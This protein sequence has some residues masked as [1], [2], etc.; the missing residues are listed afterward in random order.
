MVSASN[1]V[2][3]SMIFEQVTPSY[4]LNVA[5]SQAFAVEPDFSL[6]WCGIQGTLELLQILHL[7]QIRCQ[8]LPNATVPL[9][10]LHMITYHLSNGM[11]YTGHSKWLNTGKRQLIWPRVIRSNEDVRLQVHPMDFHTDITVVKIS[12]NVINWVNQSLLP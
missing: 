10:I 1:E 6:R 7:P 11:T 9:L 3:L 4:L 12:Q 5:I 2:S 8:L